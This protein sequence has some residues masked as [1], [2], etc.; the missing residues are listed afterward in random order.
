MLVSCLVLVSLLSSPA[1]SSPARVI[2]Q[3][4]PKFKN[5]PIVGLKKTVTED[6]ELESKSNA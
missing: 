3:R 6:V 4:V 2:K 5:F 1:L